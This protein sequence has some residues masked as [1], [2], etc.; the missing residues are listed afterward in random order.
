[1]LTKNAKELLQCKNEIAKL[2]EMTEDRV[3]QCKKDKIK[4]ERDSLE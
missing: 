4:F 3:I 1:M 2:K